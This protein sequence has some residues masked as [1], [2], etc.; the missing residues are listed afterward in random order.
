MKYVKPFGAWSLNENAVLDKLE[1]LKLGLLDS[2]QG[3]IIVKCDVDWN[4]IGQKKFD[5]FDQPFMKCYYYGNWPFDL[6]PEDDWVEYPSSY[7]KELY[8]NGEPGD[9]EYVDLLMIHIAGAHGADLLW[10][11]LDDSLID[12]HTGE[13]LGKATE[14]LTENRYHDWINLRKIGLVEPAA[15]TRGMIY[16]EPSEED[17]REAMEVVT[18][19]D[20]VAKA[21]EIMSIET[22]HP[23]ARILGQTKAVLQAAAE[24]RPELLADIFE[25]YADRLRGLYFEDQVVALLDQYI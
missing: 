11:K 4:R 8:L 7:L 18:S 3:L 25:P 17:R 5:G 13:Y 2:K 22:H 6:E 24:H 21:H 19:Q 20:P 10:T 23:F 1:L 12:P 15:R 14:I 9:V 16:E